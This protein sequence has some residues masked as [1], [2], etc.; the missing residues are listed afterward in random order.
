MIGAKDPDAPILRVFE[1]DFYC[2]SQE[3][4]ESYISFYYLIYGYVFDITFYRTWETTGEVDMRAIESK[5]FNVD[6]DDGLA[7]GPGMVPTNKV[8]SWI[9]DVLRKRAK[10]DE[11]DRL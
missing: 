6:T 1:E 9:E 2:M 4:F 10:E 8:V 7:A 11:N 3:G 5:R